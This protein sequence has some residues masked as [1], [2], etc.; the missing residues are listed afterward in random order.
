MSDPKLDRNQWRTFLKILGK[1]KNEVRL[2][3]FYPKGHPL[4]NTDRGKKSNA[5]IEWITQCQSEGRG[6]YVVVNDGGDTDSEITACRAFFCEW[7]DR[8]KEEQINAWSLYKSRF[9]GESYSYTNDQNDIEFIIK[10]ERHLLD[11]YRRIYPDMLVLENELLVLDR[12]KTL[13]TLERYIEGTINF[14]AS[15]DYIAKTMSAGQLSSIR[16]KL[17]TSYRFYSQYWPYLAH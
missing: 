10:S 8:S 4:K 9:A 16:R 7:D 2:R 1:D 13:N 6:V 15:K 5:N 12:E 3:S 17:D 14:E 11:Q